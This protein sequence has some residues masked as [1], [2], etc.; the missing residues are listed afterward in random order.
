LRSQFSPDAVQKRHIAASVW[1][2]SMRGNPHRNWWLR[3]CVPWT[4]FCVHARSVRELATLAAVLQFATLLMFGSVNATFVAIIVAACSSLLI[5][6]TLS[7]ARIGLDVLTAAAAMG[8]AGVSY[9]WLAEMTGKDWPN[10]A[11][12]IG[13]AAL[14]YAAAKG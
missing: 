9:G 12:P 3:P 1:S 6:H 14:V 7:A 5:L 10:H 13:L 4:R 2:W 8:A 11:L